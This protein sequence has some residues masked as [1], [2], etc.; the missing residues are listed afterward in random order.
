M[1]NREKNNQTPSIE[2]S[3]VN[4]AR[5]SL[6]TEKTI[7]REKEQLDRKMPAQ[8]ES[9]CSKTSVTLILKLSRWEQEVSEK[10]GEFLKKLADSKKEKGRR[11]P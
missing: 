11:Q 3:A 7:A 9:F 6:A 5:S 8:K 2:V 10:H 1:V 4:S